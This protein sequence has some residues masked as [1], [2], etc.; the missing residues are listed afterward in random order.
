MPA[1][2]TSTPAVAGVR[3]RLGEI[4]LVAAIGRRSPRSPTALRSRPN[5]HAVLDLMERAG[6]ELRNGAP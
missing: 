1:R 5:S 6:S 2:L 4:L 3:L